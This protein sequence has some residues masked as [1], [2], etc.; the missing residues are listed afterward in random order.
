MLIVSTGLLSN[1][2]SDPGVMRA[3]YQRLFP[4]RALF[5]WLNHAD[6]PSSDFVHR[7]FAFTLPNDAYLRYQSFPTAD[8]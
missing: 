7:E 3:F 5:K 8:L 6:K 2:Y 4:Y 1:S